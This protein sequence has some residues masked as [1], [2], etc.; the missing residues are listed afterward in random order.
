MARGVVVAAV[1]LGDDADTLGLDAEGDDLALELVADL[2]S[3]AQLYP[4]K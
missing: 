4:V 1:G 3:G 2:S